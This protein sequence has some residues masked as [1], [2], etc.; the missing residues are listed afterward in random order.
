[1]ARRVERETRKL[2]KTV[3][4]LIKKVSA[5][6]EFKFKKKESKKYVKRVKRLCPHWYLNKRGDETPA[7]HPSKGEPEYHECGICNALIR[8]RL[9]DMEEVD[10]GIGEFLKIINQ[11]EFFA[12]ALGSDRDTISRCTQLKELIPGFRQDCKLVVKH[13]KDKNKVS[14]DKNKEEM[15]LN[16]T[17]RMYR[18]IRYR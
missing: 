4:S 16:D 18:S 3:T 6:N 9:Y 2:I 1:M 5:N 10:E 12:I 17:F 7:L 14:S 8:K 13:V 15:S 11:M